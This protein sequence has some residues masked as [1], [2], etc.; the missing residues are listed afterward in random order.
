MSTPSLLG[1]PVLL[2]N[3]V[4]LLLGPQWIIYSFSFVAFL[5]SSAFV[6]CFIS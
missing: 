1:V 3:G 5:Y 6:M 4:T 2:T